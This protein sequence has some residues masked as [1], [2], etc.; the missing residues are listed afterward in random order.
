[1]GDYAAVSSFAQAGASLGG[2]FS[3]AGAT[4]AQGDYQSQQHA[5][6]AQISELQAQDAL[7]RGVKASGDFRKQGKQLIG[8]QRAALAASGVVLDSGSAAEIQADTEAQ[9]AADAR[10]IV[11]NSWR[12]A[13]GFKVQASQSSAAARFAKLAAKTDARNTLIT[14]GLQGLSYLSKAGSQ[15]YEAGWFDTSRI[16]APTGLRVT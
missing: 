3:Q 1:M 15:A 5:F 12:E 6:N 4:K 7:K 11:S 16:N 9:V 2:A 14:G 10:T 8:R 13:W